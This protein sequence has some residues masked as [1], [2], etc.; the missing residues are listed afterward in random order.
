MTQPVICF[1]I[2]PVLLRCGKCVC[3]CVREREI[4]YLWYVTI[5]IYLLARGPHE[6]LLCD[7]NIKQRRGRCI[8]GGDLLPRFLHVVVC[9]ACPRWRIIQ[10]GGFVRRY[11]WVSFV[12]A[13]GFFSS[14]WR[15]WFLALST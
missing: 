9:F 1:Y 3:L 12:I 10:F 5:N 11:V 2:L 15:P 7:V 4:L 8:F 13:V 14:G 6:L